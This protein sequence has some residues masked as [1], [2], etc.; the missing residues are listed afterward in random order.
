[1]ALQGRLLEKLLRAD[2][3]DVRFVPSNLPLSGRFR[4][5]GRFW[6]VRTA[7]RWVLVWI[8]LWKQARHADVVHI[9]AASWLYFFAVVAPAVLAGRLRGKR[10]VLN[11]RGGAAEPFLERWGWAAGPFFRMAD[12]ITAPSAFLAGVIR[13]RMSLPVAIV[14]NIVDAS[15]FQFRRRSPVQA[16]FVVT[17]NLEP[18][19]DLPSVLR[20]FRRIQQEFPEASLWIAGTGSQE[21]H[22]RGLVAEWNLEQVRFLGHVPNQDLP[23]VFEQRDIML[24]ASTVDNFPG[25]LVEASAAGLVIVSSAAG[26]IPFIYENGKTAVLAEP[27][28]W[29]GLAQG[30]IKLLHDSTLAENMATAATAVA[31]NCDWKRVRSSLYG[32]YGFSLNPSGVERPENLACANN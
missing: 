19:Y 11:Y 31:K 14:S 6:G 27:G 29:E 10:V 2:G 13:K 1:M 3:L 25:A 22:L 32:V 9:L 8:E 21:Q 18:I 7:V 5:F 16:R 24:N 4:F 26:G 28:D 17:R 20:A 23:S 12:V 15:L 30:A